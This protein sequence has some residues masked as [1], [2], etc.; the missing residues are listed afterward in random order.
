MLTHFLA[1]FL[2]KAPEIMQNY[3]P[4]R[5][6][7]IDNY[8]KISFMLQF[9]LKSPLSFLF[10][11]FLNYRLSVLLT[12]RGHILAPHTMWTAVFVFCDGP[13]LRPRIPSSLWAFSAS[14]T[15]LN[16]NRERDPWELQSDFCS[17]KQPSVPSFIFCLFIN[18]WFVGFGVL[19][20]CLS[21]PSSGI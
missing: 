21:I 13:I 18:I 16:R 10:A 3:Y 7:L 6:F 12:I 19:T 9:W 2:V 15:I 8:Y 5:F 14:H 17:S 1:I 20:A 4:K 11:Q